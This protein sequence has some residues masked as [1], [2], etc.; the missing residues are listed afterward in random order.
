MPA[1]ALTIKTPEAE[2]Y[3][4]GNWESFAEGLDTKT[5]VDA[6][7]QTLVDFVQLQNGL[8]FESVDG[9]LLCLYS[10]EVNQDSHNFAKYYA[11][12]TDSTTIEAIQASPMAIE[13]PIGTPSFGPDVQFWL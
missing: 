3:N 6:N 5:K 8:V 7:G 11:F 2:P 10:G 4:F 1:Y 12:S 13:G 9:H